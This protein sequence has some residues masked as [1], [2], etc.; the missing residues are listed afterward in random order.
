MNGYQVIFIFASFS[1][2]PKESIKGRF[3]VNLRKREITSRIPN[4]KIKKKKTIGSDV[5]DVKA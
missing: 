2:V 1:V 5:L 3:Q 4:I